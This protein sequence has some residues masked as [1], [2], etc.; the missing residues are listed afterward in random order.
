MQGGDEAD[1]E[2]AMGLLSLIHDTGPSK[3][4]YFN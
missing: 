2:Y 3:I 1:E 4:I